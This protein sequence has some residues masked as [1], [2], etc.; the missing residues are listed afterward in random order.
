MLS[1]LN[2]FFKFYKI[3]LKII[4]QFR[5]LFF[6]DRHIEFLLQIF[7]LLLKR[8]KPSQAASDYIP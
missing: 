7:L 4:K 8:V 3:K 6:L 5:I 1:L 2:I